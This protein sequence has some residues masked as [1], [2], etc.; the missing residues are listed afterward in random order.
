MRVRRIKLK[1]RAIPPAIEE[2]DG[3]YYL[4]QTP[5]SFASVIL[6]FKEGLSPETIHR[7]CFPA[8][9]LVRIYSA[10]SFYLS[11]QEEVETYLKQLQ[12]EQDELQRRLL[13][14]HPEFIKTA[15]ELRTRKI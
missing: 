7:E 12:R 15:E 5:V 2:R 1:L 6:R 9:P 14:D 11:H 3:A 4:T 8:A 13:A 10:I